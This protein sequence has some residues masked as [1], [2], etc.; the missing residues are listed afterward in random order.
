MPPRNITPSSYIGPQ[1]RKFRIERG[2]SQQKLADRLRALGAE[3]TGW[4]Q[5]K[6]NKLERG[7]LTRVL[8]DDVFE[9][10]LALDVSPLYLLTPT[11][12]F[13]EQGNAFKVALGG[14]VSQWPRE[15][16]QWIR[17][18][19]PLGDYA[20]AAEGQRGH[21]F[22]LLGSQPYSEWG[23]LVKAGEYAKRMADFAF[24]FSPD[25]SQEEGSDG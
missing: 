14:R 16:R 10:A 22:Y 5:T 12:A 25:E 9:L 18:V 6:I 23:Q 3:R 17:G 4:S 11:E 1:V 21:Q 7:K 15:V 20:S 24:A 8:V 13:D 19:Q 2:W